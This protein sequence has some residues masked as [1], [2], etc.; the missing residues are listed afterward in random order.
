VTTQQALFAM[1]ASA[2]LKISGLA[3]AVPV[4]QGGAAD[5][6]Y[7]RPWHIFLCH[8]QAFFVLHRREK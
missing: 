8:E 1:S 2:L 7:V 6:S 4:N 3:F 5:I